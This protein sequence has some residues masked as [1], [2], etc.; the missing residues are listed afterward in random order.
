MTRHAQ[1]ASTDLLLRVSRGDVGKAEA[2]G[3]LFDLVYEQLHRLAAVLMAGERP[4]HTLQP[5][6][7]IHETYALLVD[8]AAVEWKDRA[9]F[10]G[11]AARVMR[12]ILVDHARRRETLKRGRGWRRVT[13]DGNLGLTFPTDIEWVDL[14]RVLDRLAELDPRAA[15][16]VTMRVF[17][18]MSTR[19]VAQALGVSEST[20]YKDWHFAKLWLCKEFA[21]GG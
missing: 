6:A 15:D 17:G 19:E 4:G 7:L 9:H 10:L 20:V 3:R 8:G 18:S 14:D 5:T 2:T 1:Q 21:E 13:L 12:R 16:V 11:I